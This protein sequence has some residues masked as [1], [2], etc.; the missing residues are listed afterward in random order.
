MPRLGRALAWFGFA[1][2]VGALALQASLTISEAVAAGRSLAGAVEF[3]LSFF[4]ILSNAVL[5]AVHL[6][7]AS[8][9]GMLAPLRRPVVRAAMVAVMLFVAAFYHIVLAPTFALHGAWKLAD[10]LLHYVTPAFYAGCWIAFAPHGRTRFTNIPVIIA[11][12][13]AYALLAVAR[14]AVRGEYPYPVLDAATLGLERVALNIAG[15]LLLFAL[16]CAAVIGVDR[17]LGR[18]QGNCPSPQA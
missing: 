4:T 10:I 3:L 5:A 1:I 11:W 6:A 2:G 16:L 9:A 7:I 8:E 13:F 12:P 14:G 18:I 17:G 15:L